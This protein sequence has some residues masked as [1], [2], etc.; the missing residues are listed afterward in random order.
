MLVLILSLI[1]AVREVSGKQSYF[2]PSSYACSEQFVLTQRF[3]KDRCR[4]IPNRQFSVLDI[5]YRTQI[6]YSRLD[7]KGSLSA[8]SFYINICGLQDFS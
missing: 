1:L 2:I 4:F 3:A 6:L 8:Y 5:E 7:L